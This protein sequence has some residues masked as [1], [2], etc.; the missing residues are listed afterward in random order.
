MRGKYQRR[1]W[2]ARPE[3][4]EAAPRYRRACEYQIYLPD[5]LQGDDLSFP[6]E[7]ATVVSDA[8]V[9]IANL[10]KSAA[11]ELRPLARLLL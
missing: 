7:L 1:T 4:T 8:E 2:E 9:A 6:G 10:N 3:L 5:P 11:P